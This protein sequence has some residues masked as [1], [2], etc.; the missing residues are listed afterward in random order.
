VKIAISTSGQTLDSPLDQRFGRTQGFI[1][2]DTETGEHSYRSNDQNLSLA[3]GAGI[4]AAMNVADSGAKAVIT[5]HV[6]P[7]AYLALSKGGIA[8]HLAPGNGTVAQA[9][10]DYKA[11]KLSQAQGPDKQGHW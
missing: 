11:G 4:Q 5:G 9:I 7:K 1:V 3:Q 6:G 8:I 2:Y 10:E